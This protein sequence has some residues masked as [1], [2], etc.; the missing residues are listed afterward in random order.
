MMKI[1]EIPQMFENVFDWMQEPFILL[2]T[3]PNNLGEITIGQGLVFI[4]AIIILTIFSMWNFSV[5]LGNITHHIEDFKGFNKSQ[6]KIVY[7]S[8]KENSRII[9]KRICSYFGYLYT[10]NIYYNENDYDNGDDYYEYDGD[11]DSSFNYK[12]VSANTILKNKNNKFSR[13]G[14]LKHFYRKFL[15]SLVV[16]ILVTILYVVFID[17]AESKSIYSILIL[18]NVVIYILLSY[19][20]HIPNFSLYALAVIINVFLLF[21]IGKYFLL[22]LFENGALG[23]PILFTAF[24]FIVE[25]LHFQL[26]KE[27]VKITI[28]ELEKLKLKEWSL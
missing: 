21:N 16:L 7:S 14:V 8:D 17:L 23:E 11:I 24:Y 26:D 13:Y 18:L 3:D 27:R 12:S 10:S 6:K 2:Y 19:P 28:Q 5:K 15:N 22:M 1:K 25:Y 9:S 20:F 4:I